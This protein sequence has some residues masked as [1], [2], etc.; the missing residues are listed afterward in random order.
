MRTPNNIHTSTLGALLAMV[1][2]S[3][4]GPTIVI[5]WPEGDPPESGGDG[6]GDPGDGDG[7]V[8]SDLP[9]ECA[10]GDLGCDCFMSECIGGLTCLDGVCVDDGPFD[11]F[12]E[13]D[14]D[15]RCWVRMEWWSAWAQFSDPEGLQAGLDAGN[16]TP[17][18]DIES[19]KCYQYGDPPGTVCVLDLAGVTLHAQPLSELSVVS[20]A[21]CVGIGPWSSS[22]SSTF[23]CYGR[24]G[25]LGVAL[26]SI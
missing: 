15:G 13:C 6:D 4:C 9:A 11:L 8:P 18:E 24:F 1:L 20:D 2:T 3:A 5:D 22:F 17:V 21:E 19:S 23:W 12:T 26:K 14:D 10:P 16:L 25:S 7:D